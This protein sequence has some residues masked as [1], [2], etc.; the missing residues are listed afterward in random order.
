M[1][2]SPRHRLDEPAV[3]TLLRPRVHLAPPLGWL[4]DPVG[5]VYHDGVYHCSYQHYPDALEWGPMHW[6]HATSVDLVTWTDQGIALAPGPDGMIFSG[7][8]VVDH[9]NTAGFGAGALVAY[10]TLHRDRVEAQAFAVSTDRGATWL[11]PRSEPTLLPRE[12]TPDFRDPRV[13]RYTDGGQSWW[14]MLLSVG[15]SIEF[16]RSEDLHSWQLVSTFVSPGSA[17]ET[18]ET[19]DLLLL[20]VEGEDRHTWLLTFG[21]M[22]DGPG[23]ATGMRA[24]V[25]EFDGLTFV[26]DPDHLGAVVDHGP[27]FYAA[28]SFSNAPEP[29][30]IAWLNN[31]AYAREVAAT[32]WKGM[33]TLPRTLSLRSVGGRVRL[34]QVAVHGFAEPLAEARHS[35]AS[36]SAT[37]ALPS[38]FDARLRV[39]ADAS[40]TVRLALCGADDRALVITWAPASGALEIDLTAL[41][42]T[43]YGSGVARVLPVALLAAGDEIELRVIVDAGSVEL[44]ADDGV[45][46]VSCHLPQDW[47]VA[48]LHAA[49]A[50]GSGSLHV[51]G[52]C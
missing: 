44:F 1:S 2:E 4:S 5:L 19:P 31:W 43:E 29:T 51:T 50:H 38:A 14:V 46:V 25:G 11:R 40:A 28:Q 7:S 20:P 48:E 13:I 45:T 9:E 34:R 24:V 47:R 22:V 21:F 32:E 41:R 23:S 39:V 30:W 37:V 18:W 6:R 26:A 42:G 10:F 52:W 8:A 17:T 12:S 35:L 49:A 15:R 27:D 33:L 16:Y 36:E 3:T